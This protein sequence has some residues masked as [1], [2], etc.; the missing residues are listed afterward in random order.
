MKFKSYILLLLSSFI[1]SDVFTQSYD[2]MQFIENKGQWDNSVKF[3]SQVPG[4]AVFIHETGFTVLQHNPKDWGRIQE[5]AHEHVSGNRTIDLKEKLTIRSHAY[6]VRFVNSAKQPVI[7]AD[8]PLYTYNNYFIGNDP[9]KWAANCKTYSGITIKDLYPNVDIRY[10]SNNG[11]L[12][13]D[14]IVKPGADISKIALKYEGANKLQVKN[15]ELIIETSIGNVKELYPYTYQY[16][17]TSKKEISNEYLVEDDEVRFKVK[18]HDPKSTLIIDPTLIFASFSGSTADNWGFTATYGPD[19]SMY[20]GGIVYGSGFPVS[21]GAF[22]QTFGGG[23]GTQ[24]F[25]IGIIKLTPD[26]SNR[27]YATY[28]G[29]RRGNEQPHSLVVDGQGNLILAGR[30]NSD[31]YPVTGSGQI[32]AG[33]SYDIIVTK[34][35]ATGTALIGSKKIGGGNDDGVNIRP[36]RSGATSLQRNYGD[37]GRSE[38]II[39]GAGNIYVASSSQS[40]NFPTASAFQGNNAG[41]QDAV[42]VKI[43]PDV[44]SLLFSTY[45]GG[46]GNDAAYVLSLNPADNSIY[47]GGGTESSNFPSTPGTISSNSNG[48][49]DGYVAVLSNNGSSLIRSTYI[50]TSGIDQV[51][52]VQFDRFGFP[53]IMG[54]TTGNWQIRNATWS[55][56]GGK[57]FISKLEV[58]LSSFVYSTA[59]GTGGAIPN[60]SPTAFLVDRCENVYVSGWGGSI[61]GYNSAGTFGLPV[62]NALRPTTDGKDFYF[63]V[64]KKNAT[65]Q[66]YGDFYGQI[67]GEFPDHVDGGTSRFDSDGVIYQ[68]ICANCEQPPNKPVFPTTPGVW[69]PNNGSDMCNLA[70]IKIALNLAGVQAGVQS[71]INGVPRDSSGCVP[72]TVDFTDTIQIAVSYEWNFGDGSAQITTI[73]PNTSH[74]YNAVGSYRVMLVAIDP[75]TC[76]VRDTSYITIQVGDLKAQADFN[77]VKLAPCDSFR[78]RFDNISTAPASRPF[79]PRSFIWDFGD[80]SQR[81]TAGATSMFHTYRSPGTYNVKLFLTDSAFCNFPDSIVKQVRVAAVVKADFETPQAGCVPYTAQFKNTSE[82]G[83][84][85]IWNFGDGTTTTGTNPSH[86]YNAA[87]T[88]TV[89]LI[90]IDSATCNISDSATGTIAIYNNPVADFSVAPQPPIVNTPIIFTNLSSQEAV[91]FLWNFGDGD[92]IGTRSRQPV[93][94]E[95]NAS[96]TFDACLI[97]FNANGC[98]DTICRPVTALIE[99]AMDVPNAF[100]PLSGDVN[101]KVFVR[102]FGIAKM[103]FI[104][105]NRWGQKVFESDSKN[106]GWDG[107]YKGVLQPMDVY[108]YTL[109]VE[110]SDGTRTSKKGDIT[111]IR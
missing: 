58:D 77:S 52:G 54:Q 28:I 73:T 11:Q 74:I 76:N 32:G 88:Y 29:G 37:D 35:N 94:H 31:D 56:P 100:T 39:D 2:A 96:K 80:G 18:Q 23:P 97:A 38:V 110:F 98:P 3:M 84:Q 65:A 109:E 7:V 107:R 48:N 16:S 17:K 12:K 21:P 53:Y 22:Q 24:P 10:Y 60:I 5:I 40:N 59:F 30:T 62:V 75:A 103:K 44:S 105:W 57:Q 45:L 89:K 46:S 1:F 64:L 111:L 78:F 4:G 43:T 95:Y 50:G 49:I 41:A 90:A 92:T 14:L 61:A 106:I 82:G 51:Y 101:S 71:A 25:D 42:V 26:G 20:G 70:M 66:L 108:A 47:V 8:K 81:V 83:Q 72:L 63:F 15:K 55:Q 19:G 6:K 9:S 91:R 27:V 85:F 79:A 102:G 13:Y 68:A 34:L 86:T 33:G 99:A 69:A 93:S 104:I 87:G 67:G 36:T